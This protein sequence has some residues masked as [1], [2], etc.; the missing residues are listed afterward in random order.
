[1]I[2]MLGTEC[3]IDARGIEGSSY[4]YCHNLLTKKNSKQLSTY[5][6]IKY[7]IKG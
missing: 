4:S 7:C 3:V 5:I 1:M 6:M 2:I